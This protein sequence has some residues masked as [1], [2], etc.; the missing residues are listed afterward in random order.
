[1][2]IVDIEEIVD[3]EEFETI[4]K[5]WIFGYSET[6]FLKIFTNNT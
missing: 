2:V 1:M 5:S 4:R 3:D 6:K